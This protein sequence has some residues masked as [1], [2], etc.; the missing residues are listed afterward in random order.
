MRETYHQLGRSLIRRTKSLLRHELRTLVVLMLD[1]MIATLLLA[2]VRKLRRF[3]IHAFNF[4][5]VVSLQG[6]LR[7]VSRLEGLLR[8]LQR[9]RL[10]RVGCAHHD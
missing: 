9:S 1:G 4:T 6:T 8:L 7:R 10:M 3:G 5:L 2:I